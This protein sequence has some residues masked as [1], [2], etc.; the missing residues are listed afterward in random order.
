MSSPDARQGPDRIPRVAV[1]MPVRNAARYLDASIASV[2]GQTHADFEFIALDDASTDGSTDILASWA[3]RDRRLRVERSA[4]PL[5]VVESSNRV[6]LASRAALVARMDA[7]DISHP[8]RLARQVDAFD[9]HPGAAL[10]GTLFEGIDGDGRIVRTRDRWRLLFPSPFAPF[11]HGSVMF[12]REAFDA[13]G[14][15][16]RRTEYWEDLDLFHR[17]AAVGSVLVLTQALYR[18]RFHTTNVRL[19]S[20]REEVEEAVARMLVAFK[21]G[22]RATL[23]GSRPARLPDDPHVLYSLAASRIW[24]GEPPELWSRL[25]FRSL[26]RPSP[27]TAAIFAVAAMA[28]AS[29]KATRYLLARIIATR[30]RLASLRVGREPFEWHFAS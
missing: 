9:R 20:E 29:P 19:V 17:L 10:V 11:P 15:Y 8:E 28:A 21:P 30:D 26:L 2:L 4:R 16:D 6:V 25:G 27:S 24:A 13:I 5:G 7:D 12:R 1:V 3:A 14:G 23:N 18:Y 22:G